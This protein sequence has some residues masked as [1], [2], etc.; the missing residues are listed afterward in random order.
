MKGEFYM[1][2]RWVI[3]TALLG[4]T[5]CSDLGTNP[6]EGWEE[7]E[8]YDLP[9]AQIYLP[10]SLERQQTVAVGPQNPI[11]AGVVDN[12][13]VWVEFCLYATIMPSAW[14]DYEEEPTTLYCRQAVLF[15][16]TG[17][18]HPYDSSFQPLM[19]IRAYFNPN[20]D[21]VEV[22]VRVESTS[23]YTIARQILMSLHPQPQN[24]GMLL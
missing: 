3:A 9:Y 20:G 19:G 16:G 2:S 13:R 22:V 15:H 21:S 17:L 10:H 18:L 11:W 24:T 12:Q 8:E 23:G 4:L 7:W 6:W 1:H 5:A 14:L